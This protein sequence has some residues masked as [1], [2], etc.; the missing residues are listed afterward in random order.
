LCFV[1]ALNLLLPASHVVGAMKIPIFYFPYERYRASHP[2]P[3]VSPTHYS[4]KG[5][6]AWLSKDGK[7]ALEMFTVAIQIDSRFA[8][9]YLNRGIVHRDLGHL[10]AAQDD[11]ARAM[12]ISPKMYEAQLEWARLLELQGDRVNAEKTLRTLLN[13]AP[14]DSK[15]R[16][17]VEAMLQRLITP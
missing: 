11:I 2:P 7:V 17:S 12:T 4:N 3:E 6:Q 15:L 5:V 14:D 10:E 16:P 8:E 9:G 13:D 1:T